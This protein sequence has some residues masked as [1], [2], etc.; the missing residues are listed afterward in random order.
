MDGHHFPNLCLMKLSGW[1]KAKGDTV[2]WWSETAEIYDVVYMA[3]VF[4][5]VYSPD[6]PTPTNATKVVRGGTG[7]AIWLEGDKEVYHKEYDPSLA[8]E[9][10]S[11]YPDYSLYP[12]YTGWG[13]SLKKQTAY[14]FL[15]R[16]CPRGCGFCHVAPKE[17]RCAHKVADL[18]Q[19]WN[20][21]GN[22]CLSD[23]NIL[24]CKDAPDLLAQ[25][26]ES[27]ARVEFNQ[28]LDARLLTP[29]KAELLARMNLKTPHF[30][31]DS[32]E[33]IKPVEKGLRLYVDACKRIKGKWNWRNGKVFCLT[34]FDTSHEQDMERIK[35]IQACECWPFVMI[36]NKPSAPSITRRLQRWTNNP[37]IYATAQD[38]MDFQRQQ[39]KE[40]L[41]PWQQDKKESTSAWLDRLLG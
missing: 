34:N 11:F 38:F 21:Q 9:I 26:V 3:K 5:D 29:Q 33:A 10:E 24:A 16:G 40:V 27:G 6:L 32:M 18:K 22:I 12:E 23:P 4:S 8:P 39:Y 31:M 30:A 20:G 37:I 36:Y 1:H 41:Y 13:Q 19:F 15:T 7:Y 17:G 35:V 14:G 28:G 25:L 2:E